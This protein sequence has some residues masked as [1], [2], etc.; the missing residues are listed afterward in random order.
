MQGLH[1]SRTL[2]IILGASTFPES[3]QLLQG[4]FFYNSAADFKDYLLDPQA[5][6]LPPQ[7]LLWLFD[8]SR[9][10][11][12]QLVKTAEFLTRRDLELKSS[13]AR[14]DDLLVFY[15]GHGLFARGA[16]Q[17][18]CLAL[19]STNEINEGATSLRAAELAGVVKERAA[20]MRRYLILDCCFAASVYKEFQSGPLTAAH[21][22]IRK[23]FPERGTAVM[24]S[25]NAYEPARAPQGLGHT[26][27]SAALMRA[28]RA[29]HNR[30]GPQLSF[31]E[32][33]DLVSENLRETF[34][35]SWVR[36]EVHSPDQREGDVAHLPLFP[37]PAYTVSAPAKEPVATSPA[38]QRNVQDVGVKK[39]SPRPAPKPAAKQP[40]AKAAEPRAEQLR[41]KSDREEAKR[42]EDDAEEK[43]R[44]AQDA[45]AERVLE[46]TRRERAKRQE[47]QRL[48]RQKELEER[49]RQARNAAKPEQTVQSGSAAVR[50]AGV[51]DKKQATTPVASAS[52]KSGGTSLVVLFLLVIPAVNVAGYY[53]GKLFAYQAADGPPILHNFWLLLI[54]WCLLG[55]VAGFLT[56][57][58]LD[59]V[60]SRKSQTAACAMWPGFIA[61]FV[62]H[63]GMVPESATTV[64]TLS[65]FLFVLAA[66]YTLIDFEKQ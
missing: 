4:R 45:A 66:L 13:G 41:P 6:G 5:M 51:L 17:A 23:E 32:L 54:P 10:A 63:Q 43:R 33:G 38:A 28:L 65:A 2:A 46:Q 22:Q 26:M 29:G 64:A 21:V 48:A 60:F 53:L 18:Y 25:S 61:G 39:E 30:G 62:L 20:F 1:T 47:Q 35:D 57:L 37:N 7:N 27:F 49:E 16:D 11:S 3:P 36:P 8:D 58:V 19:R 52:P 9:S 50:N 59:T 15:V 40:P 42:R 14:P 31:S 55:I 24:C 12:E 44:A 56:G 34:P